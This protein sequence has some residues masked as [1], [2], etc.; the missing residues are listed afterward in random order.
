MKTYAMTIGPIVETLSLGRKTAEIWGASYMFSWVMKNSVARLREKGARFIVPYAGSD[1]L[2][3]E[4]DGG[5]GRFHD[6]FI[7]QSDTLTLEEVGKIVEA[8]RD[9]L[10]AMIHQSLTQNG[11]PNEFR[12][13]IPL[14]EVKRQLRDYIQISIIEIPEELDNPILDTSKWLDSAELHTPALPHGNEAIRRFIRREVILNSPLAVES[15]GHKPSFQSIPAIAAQENWD[16]KK[17]E[18]GGLKQI[19]KYIAIVHADG[20]NLGSVIKKYGK[21]GGEFSK[22][23]FDF[24]ESA[25]K[26]LDDYGAQTLFIGGDD[27]LFFAPVMDAK[28]R[29]IYDLVDALSQAYSEAIGDGE[30][31][32]SFGVSVTYYK[33]PLYEALERSRNALFGDA[34]H[35]SGKN[36]VCLSVQKHSGQ[37][38]RFTLGKDEKAYETFK[39]LLKAVLNEEAKIPHDLHHKL[40]SLR[41]VLQEAGTERLDNVFENFFNE[42]IHEK[43]F[44][45]GLRLAQGLLKETGV[46]EH[47]LQKAES[48]ISAVKLLRGDR[49]E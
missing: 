23:L 40:S 31:T 5:V 20:D 43:E 19:E 18:N 26:I 10:A 41:P 21:N 3:E 33:Y 27:L 15:F 44:K 7:C 2:F 46:D 14:E 45:E 30:T 13:E 6:R 37:S 8:V 11:V 35:Y 12:Y 38:F 34:K 48:M 22:K 47:S 49:D 28:G 9:E 4:N 29:T 17:E 25:K 42:E 36:A 16:E 39:S 32:L 24:A 1:D